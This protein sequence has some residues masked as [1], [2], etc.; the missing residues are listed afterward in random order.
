MLR[1]IRLI[2]NYF[3]YVP[4][5]FNECPEGM[6]WQEIISEV[7]TLKNTYAAFINSFGRFCHTIN[8]CM[9]IETFHEKM[10]VRT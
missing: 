6:N 8:R 4:Y 1:Y 9:V 3:L 7:L 5:D 10:S 2:E